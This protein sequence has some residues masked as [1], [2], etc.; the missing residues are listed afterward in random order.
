MIRSLF[1]S[2]I[3]VLL[4][5]P[6][7]V[8]LEVTSFFYVE[9]VWVHVNTV[10]WPIHLQT[11]DSISW[12]LSQF[13]HPPSQRSTVRRSH[14][15]MFTLFLGLSSSFLFHRFTHH[16]VFIRYGAIPIAF[17]CKLIAILQS[18]LPEMKK[19]LYIGHFCMVLTA[20]FPF[21]FSSNFLLSFSLS[22]VPAE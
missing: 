12:S 21:P 18:C 8:C 11:K 2:Y 14:S 15:W 5:H 19:G 6:T 17:F 20:S 7:L 22:P 1:S 4:N 3:K 10:L 13:F 9:F 16:V